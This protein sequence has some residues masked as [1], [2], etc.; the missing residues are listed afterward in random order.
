MT[1][2]QDDN[3]HY[4]HSHY[5]YCLTAHTYACNIVHVITTAACSCRIIIALIASVLVSLQ[6]SMQRRPHCS[7]VFNNYHLFHALHMPCR[8]EPAEQKPQE[9]LPVGGTICGQPGQGVLA[10]YFPEMSECCE[11]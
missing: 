4:H 11:I 7:D 5:H 6:S 10:G 9:L 2:A 8:M 3:W 1:N